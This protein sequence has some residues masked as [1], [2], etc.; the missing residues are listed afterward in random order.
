MANGLRADDVDPSGT[1]KLRRTWMNLKSKVA[2][3]AAV[4]KVVADG[5]AD[6]GDKLKDSRNPKLPSAI[7]NAIGSAIEDI[8]NDLSLLNDMR[9][10]S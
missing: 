1:E 3:D 5:E 6:A 10:G 8:E 7:S 9:K 2:D 4:I